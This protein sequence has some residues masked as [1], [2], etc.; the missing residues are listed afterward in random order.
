MPGNSGAII[1]FRLTAAQ[2][3]RLD[4]M[5][6]E[7]SERL[8]RDQFAQALMV[9]LLEDDAAAHGRPRLVGGA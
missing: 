4:D 3:K 2:T 7:N 5:R 1:V 8:T 9:S 6:A